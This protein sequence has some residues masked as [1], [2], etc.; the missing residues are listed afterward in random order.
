MNRTIQ[1]NSFAARV[2]EEIRGRGR[3]ARVHGDHG[4]HVFVIDCSGLGIRRCPAEPTVTFSVSKS[5]EAYVHTYEPSRVLATGFSIVSGVA[6]IR[7]P[8]PICGIL[9]QT[10]RYVQRRA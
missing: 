1:E 9:T 5:A 4:S 3:L 2:T 8:I 6:V 7:I 10:S